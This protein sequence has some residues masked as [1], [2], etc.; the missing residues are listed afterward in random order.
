MNYWL[1][2][3]EPEAYSIA[4]LQKEGRTIWDGVR[5][6]QAR[7]FLRQMRAGDLCFFYHSNANPS[8]IVGMARV[9][10]G[11]IIDPAQFDPESPYYDDKS[12]RES[13]RWQTVAIEFVDTFSEII[14]LAILKQKFTPEELLVVK[15][16]NR[17]SVMPVNRETAEKILDLKSIEPKL[18][19]KI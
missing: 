9:V 18:K 4:D 19:L 16:G 3:S 1:L 15:K 6:Y 2:K 17:L 14:S 10:T 5:N 7:N 11:E 8:G 12:T 13:P